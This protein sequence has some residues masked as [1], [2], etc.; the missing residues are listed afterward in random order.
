MTGPAYVIP[1]AEIDQDVA[2]RV[3]GK[4]LALARMLRAGIAVPP[5]VAVTTDAYESY[6]DATGL[7]VRILLELERK[8]FTEMRWEELWDQALRIR[9]LFLTTPLPEE[10]RAA[11]AQPLAAPFAEVASWSAVAA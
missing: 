10:L 2:A 8:D 6:L 4:A 5:F 1:A 9:N 11:L 3:G 7:R